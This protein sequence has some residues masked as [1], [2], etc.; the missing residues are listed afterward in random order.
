MEEGLLCSSLQELV[1]AES[2]LN[3]LLEISHLTRLKKLY[4]HSNKITSLNNLQN[5]TQLEVELKIHSNPYFLVHLKVLW[6]SN[7]LLTNLESIEKLP[8]MLEE[9]N[10]AANPLSSINN[11]ISVLTNLTTLNL[12]GTN[13]H[14][15]SVN[16]APKRS[17]LSTLS[18]VQDLD[19][20][21][22][23][24]LLR[25]VKFSDPLW[26]R[27]PISRFPNYHTLVLHRLRHLELLDEI[28]ITAE[29]RTNV[30]RTISRKLVYYETQKREIKQRFD[31][32]CLKTENA[33]RVILFTMEY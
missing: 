14:S 24:P 21:S 4:L 10:L 1:L 19:E 29:M 28:S 30:E 8:Q 6:L 23:L 20:L 31:E 13:L 12:A 16:Q 18:A 17:T 32:I 26:G 25:N 7:N 5:L 27:S 3:S 9:L 22:L 2:S 33:K 11:N 15:F